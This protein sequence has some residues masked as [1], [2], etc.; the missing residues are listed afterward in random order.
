MLCKHAKN[1]SCCFLMCGLGTLLLWNSLRVVQTLVGAGHV[2]HSGRMLAVKWLI[3]M[4]LEM[5]GTQLLFIIKR[6]NLNDLIIIIIINIL[7]VTNTSIATTVYLWHN[8]H[9]KIFIVSAMWIWNTI[10]E[11]Q[12]LDIHCLVTNIINSGTPAGGSGHPD[13]WWATAIS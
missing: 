6:L 7:T 3:L 11:V 2:V 9:A 13:M 12:Y 5:N 4:S 10:L 1:I 8:F